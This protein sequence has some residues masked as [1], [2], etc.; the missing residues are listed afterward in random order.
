MKVSP[1]DVTGL[2]P[3]DFQRYAAQILRDLVDAVNGNLTFSE[4]FSGRLITIAF[5]GANTDTSA[6]HGLGRLPAGYI[7]AG[8]SA[9]MTV[10]DA[11]SNNP[12]TDKL[13]FLRSSA[14]GTAQVLVF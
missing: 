1:K 6:A 11:S 9:A 4:N 5:S 3:E 7:V 12:D 8:L 13:I 14:T 10:Y 2:S